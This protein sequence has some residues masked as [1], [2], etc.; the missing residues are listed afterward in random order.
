MLSRKKIF[1][2]IA[3]LALAYGIYLRLINLERPLIYDEVWG[4]MNWIVK[5]VSEILT[6][7]NNQNN[8]PL[9]S[10]FMKLSNF[11]F[12]RSLIMMRMHSFA[13][14][15][16][17][18][19]FSGA[20]AWHLTRKRFIAAVTII[21]CSLHSGLIYYSHVARGYSVQTAAIMLFILLV[22]VYNDSSKKTGR[23]AIYLVVGMIGCFVIACFALSTAILYLSAIMVMHVICILLLAWQRSNS[24]LFEMGTSAVVNN[25]VLVSGYAVI[26]LF[27]AWMYLGHYAQFKSAVPAGGGFYINSFAD[28][29]SFLSEMGKSLLPWLVWCSALLCFRFKKYRLLGLM[30]SCYILPA[31]LSG[32][33]IKVGPPRV[34]LPLVPVII[35]AASAGV[36]SLTM[37][38]KK[39]SR[40]LQ[41][42]LPL[43]LV[44]FLIF[45][46]P[47][48]YLKWA[49]IDWSNIISDVNSKFPEHKS[50]RCYPANETLPISASLP[51]EVKNNIKPIYDGMLFI[52]F[53]RDQRIKGLNNKNGVGE[54]EFHSSESPPLVK[55]S[56]INANVYVLKKVVAGSAIKSNIIFAEIPLQDLKTARAAV[57]F[58]RTQGTEWYLLNCWFKPIRMSQTGGK[59]VS[60]QLISDSS[61][62]SVAELLEIEQ[63][64]FDRVRFFWLS[65]EVKPDNR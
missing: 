55:F 10:V 31:F 34:Y 37:V 62:L 21:L 42:I 40:P 9:N 18:P 47:E 20:I 22:L 46:L 57:G 53:G 24:K 6:L 8:H 5:P 7:F 36:Y 44:M 61:K 27:A 4:L 60:Y 25:S 29:L 1:I 28:I 23:K 65:S 49:A 45:S 30:T 15:I 19:L 54:V 56:Q 26:T 51:D 58:L 64:S 35:I 48:R 32:V 17:I 33:F 41:I 12:G 63:R 59:L 3:L 39:W 50:Y 52:N 2:G 11:M 43:L 13:A 38:D 14:G 16:L